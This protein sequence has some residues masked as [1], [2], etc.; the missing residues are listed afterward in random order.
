VKVVSPAKNAI[1]IDAPSG[2]RYRAR[3]GIYD[4]P[5]RD[6]KA[7]LKAGGALPNQLGATSAGTGFRCEACRFGSFF[8][9]CSRCGGTCTKET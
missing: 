4:V 6:A 2:R 5:D 7:L 1:E 9:T 3:D 8:T